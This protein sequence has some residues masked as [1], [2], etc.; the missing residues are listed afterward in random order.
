MRA[1][2]CPDVDSFFCASPQYSRILAGNSEGPIRE[3]PKNTSPARIIITIIASSRRAFRTG[4]ARL[5]LGKSMPTPPCSL[6]VITMKL[7]MSTSRILANALTSIRQT[8]CSGLWRIR[9]TGSR[10]YLRLQRQCSCSLRRTSRT[11]CEWLLLVLP[12]DRQRVGP[13]AVSVR[14]GDH[15]GK[16]SCAAFQRCVVRT[17]RL[18]IPVVD[19]Q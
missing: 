10:Y 6:G 19:L 11:C 4:V 9:H 16:R 2:I 14:R 3:L 5:T 13:L 12:G 17:A 8:R 1:R 18:G 15:D 7:T